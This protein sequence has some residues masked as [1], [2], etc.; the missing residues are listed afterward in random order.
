[1]IPQLLFEILAIY[2]KLHKQSLE[3]GD[4]CSSQS[5]ECLRLKVGG[6]QGSQED[7][8]QGSPYQEQCCFA[9]IT[10]PLFL[11]LRFLLISELL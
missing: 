4:I 9:L 10:Q 8:S 2:P 3:V 1:M 5:V 7:D 11:L 6:N